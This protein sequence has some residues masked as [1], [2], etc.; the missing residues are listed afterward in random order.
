LTRDL[1][2][3]ILVASRLCRSAHPPLRTKC[4]RS[5]FPIVAHR[6]RSSA[7]PKLA[8]GYY[9]RAF[10]VSAGA[11]GSRTPCSLRHASSLRPGVAE[12]GVSGGA[13]SSMPLAKTLGSL[14]VAIHG[15][16]RRAEHA[17]PAVRC[18]LKA[19]I[20]APRTSARRQHV[21]ALERDI[22]T[23]ANAR[24]SPLREITRSGFAHVPMNGTRVGLRT[25][26][27]EVR[28][29]SWRAES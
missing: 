9:A 10:L 28:Y 26:G 16:R 8:T 4:M 21:G 23:H 15:D 2:G 18:R 5:A 12:S 11:P 24:E 1:L 6:A 13:C 17:L 27:S 22:P 19:H 3:R 14:T 29:G 20:R 7:P 25:V